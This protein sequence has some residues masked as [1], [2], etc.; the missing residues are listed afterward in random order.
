M[1]ERHLKGWLKHGDF[2]ILDIL[3]M[4][5]SFSISYWIRFGFGNPFEEQT[6]QFQ[7][8]IFFLSQLVIV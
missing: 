7:A 3:C 8:V 4:A 5:L 2:I 6:I 1:S